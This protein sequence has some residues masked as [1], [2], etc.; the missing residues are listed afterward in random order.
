MLGGTWP[1]IILVTTM[2]RRRRKLTVGENVIN[3]GSKVTNFNC[4]IDLFVLIFL[5]LNFVKTSV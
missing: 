1:G 5:N 2:A 4:D 3:H